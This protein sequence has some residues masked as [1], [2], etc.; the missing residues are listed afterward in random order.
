[1]SL[2]D[3]QSE[4]GINRAVWSQIERGLLMPGPLHLAMLGRT[5]GVPVYEFRMRFVVEVP[6]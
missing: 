5:F 3:L 4:T 1:M 2:R 6:A